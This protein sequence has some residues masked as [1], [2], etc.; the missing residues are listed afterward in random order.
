MLIGRVCHSEKSSWPSITKST[1]GTEHWRP[2]VCKLIEENS[3]CLLNVYVDETLLYQTVYIHLLNHTDIRLA[4]MSLFFRKD[5][6]GIYGAAGQ[7]WNSVHPHE[8]IYI[9]FNNSDACHTWLALLRSYAIPEIYGRWFFPND[10]GSYRMWRQVELTV[11]QAR[12]LGNTKTISDPGGPPTYLQKPDLVVVD[13]TDLDV[14]CEVLLNDI[15]C[16]RTTVKRASGS[17]DWHEGFVFSDLPPFD[18][19]DVNV[20]QDKKTPVLMGTVRVTLA[21]FP[22][23]HAV[24]GWYPILQQCSPAM[25]ADIQ[26]GEIKLKIRVDEEIILPSLAYRD[27]LSTFNSRNFLD[28][29]IDFETQLRLKTISSQLMSIAVARNVH[30]ENIKELADREVHATSSSH[31]TLFRGN[32]TLTK[33]MELYMTGYC[34]PFLEASIGSCV[35]RLFMEKVS[36]EVDPARSNKSSRDLEKNMDL[37]NYWCQEFWR[38][39]YAV[40]FECPNEMRKLFEHIRKLVER[41][42][43]IRDASQEHNRELPWQSVS[44]FCFLRFI[45]PAIL[46][47]H[48]FGLCPGLPSAGVQRSL[49]LITK[50]IQSLANLNSTIQ[51]EE[52]MRGVQGFLQDSKPAMVDYILVVSTPTN[53]V[54]GASNHSGA[55]RHERLQIANALRQRVSLMA[56]L[57]R[58]AIP[59]PPHLLDITRHLAIVTSAVIRSAGDY[60]KQQQGKEDT[61]LSDFCRQCCTVESYALDRVS[62]LATRIS[63]DRRRGSGPATAPLVPTQVQGAPAMATGSSQPV[64]LHPTPKRS[65]KSTRPSTAPP[66]GS[67]SDG[68]R[69][70]FMS[71]DGSIPSSPSRTFTRQPSGLPTS[72][73][74]P[75]TEK[76]P[77]RRLRGIRLKSSSSESIPTY[78]INPQSVHSHPNKPVDPPDG[79][80]DARK[81]VKGLLKGIRLRRKID[82]I[83]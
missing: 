26:V 18:S 50:V 19:L 68:S 71:T 45:T 46:H 1:T 78:G 67:D 60:M 36:I 72:I 13:S 3:R 5:C 40:R 57:P 35:R 79:S 47:P 65:R 73:P 62:Q 58:E 52:F 69:R 12:N 30:I 64:P 49:T 34:K 54:H 77:R 2:A 41:K 83:I 80:D 23:G 74:T 61:P 7:R 70:H 28:W 11:V 6:I 31:Q 53:D 76:E 27:L 59:M 75:S 56:V 14:S 20:W 66:G 42:Y 55:D 39:I 38:Q 43:N 21:N 22:R 25:A 15:L 16:G 37:L 51:K 10:G 24:E 63:S 32:T 4:D 81:G 33:T 48:L 8:P 82:G 9:Q 17:P 44:A 29:V